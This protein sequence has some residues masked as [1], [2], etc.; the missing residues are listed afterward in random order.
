MPGSVFHALTATTPDNTS[1]EIR[2]Q[3]HWN[4][5][6]L[7]TFAL[8]GSEVIGA[9]TNANGVSFGLSNSSI[10]ASVSAPINVSA[11]N[12]SGNVSALT[13][14][15]SNGLAFGFNN[16]VV[17]G[18]YTVPSTA[19][20]LTGINVSAPGSSAN[21]SAVVF[22]NANGL[23]FGLNGSTLTGAYSQAAQTSLSFANSNGLGF[24]IVGSTL[25]GSYTQAAQTSLS[26]ASGNGIS[27]GINGATLNATISQTNL[28][29]AVSLL[30]N[31]TSGALALVSSGTLFLAG[32]NNITL[33]Q[34]GNS[35][36]VIGPTVQGAQTGISG[37]IAAGSTL[38]SGT[39][40]FSNAVGGVAFGLNGATLTASVAPQTGISSIAVAGSTISNGVVM[41]SNANG[42]SFGLNGS[43]ITASYT[44][45]TFNQTV[46]S[47]SLYASSNTYGQASSTVVDAR[48]ITIIGSG[49]LYAGMSAGA[50]VLS[51]PIGNFQSVGVS[52]GGNTLGNTGLVNQQIVFVGSNNVQLSQSTAA[53][54]SATVSIIASAVAL[55]V[56]AASFSSG[57]VLLSNANGM[58]FGTS[59]GGQIVTASYT[60]PST[61]GLISAVNVSAG[62]ASSN[63]SALSLANM[64]GVS[65]G[66]T[67]G[68]LSASIPSIGGA[69]TGIS[70]IAF[71]NTTF[72]SGGFSFLNANA[73]SFGS[74]G[75]NGITAS[76]STSQSVQQLT[77][78]ATSNTIA[79]EAITGTMDARSISIAGSGN[80]S[81]GYSNGS[82]VIDSP[83][84]NFQSVGVSTGGNTLGNTGLVNQQI[85]FV[86]SNNISLSQSTVAGGS[87]TISIIGNTGVLGGV[88]A[89]FTNGASTFTSGTVS[90]SN[91]NGI[92]F[93]PNGANVVTASYSVPNVAGLISNITVSAAGAAAGAGSS[94]LT[95]ISFANMNG[96]SFG[97]TN[98]SLSAS[99][100][101]IG[102]AQTGISTIAFANTTFTS[103]GFSFL[104]ANSISFGSS[105]ANGITASYAQSVQ[106]L[107]MYA[108]SN[109]IAGQSTLGTFD[110]RSIS[111]AGSGEVSIGYS[112]GSL[113]IGAPIGSFNSIGVSN[114][115]STA[116]S[117]GL[118][119]NQVVLAASGNMLLS[120]STAAGGSATIS[121]IAQAVG[122]QVTN[123]TFT[124]GNVIFSNV[125][126]GVQF[127]TSAGGQIVTASYTVPSTAGLISA[128]NVSAGAASSNLSALS[129]GNANNMSFGYS[130][131]SI[132]GSFSSV[133]PAAQTGISTVAFANTT[134]TSGGFS[135]L[136]ANSISFGSSGANGITASYAQSAQSLGFFVS[137]NTIAGNSTSATMDART[138]IVIGAGNVSLGFSQTLGSN[139]LAISDSYTQSNQSISVYAG[140][141]GNQT[142]NTSAA[143]D[144]RSLSFVG[145]GNISVGN[146]AGAV[147]IYGTQT[148]TA[149]GLSTQGNTGGT[150]GIA[151]N[152]IVFVG[153]NNITLSQS[154]TNGSATISIFGPGGIAAAVSGGG[155][156]LTSGTLMFSNANN[157]TFGY[158]GAAS[159][160][161]ASASYPVQSTQP[162]AA[163]GSNGSIGFSTLTFGS[164]NNFAF[165]ITNGSLVGSLASTAG[166]ALQA[167]TQTGNTSGSVVFSSVTGNG[168][169]IVFGMSNS[170]VITASYSQSA[171]TMGV[172]A[173]GNTTAQSTFSTYDARSLYVSGAGAISAGFSAGTLVISNSGALVVSAGTQAVGV[174]SVVFSS[175]TG[176]GGNIA[177][178]MSNSSVVTASYS[179]SN[180]TMSVQLYGSTTNTTATTVDARSLN[181]S[182]AGNLTVGYSASTLQFS[183]PLVGTNSFLDPT[184]PGCLIGTGQC[185]AG[186]VMVFP[187][188]LGG[189][190][191]LS[192]GVH[193]AYLSLST[194]SNS[195]C[196]ASISMYMGIYS[197]NGSTLN[198]YVT[199]SQSYAFSNTSNNSAAS[200]SGLRAFTVPLTGASLTPGDY[201]VVFMSN[202]TYGGNNWV[203]GSNLVA[204]NFSLPLQGSIGQVGVAS[205]QM[206]MG[207]GVYSAT[208]NALPAGMAFTN[209]VGV[210]TANP[211][212]APYVNFN[213]FSV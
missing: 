9:F 74:S 76:F 16:G 186:S 130:N 11:G 58:S 132:T 65:F 153:T 120:Q 87:A 125:A 4:A 102:G 27:F 149:G 172:Y 107:S 124:S 161:T 23:S 141:A 138:F 53:G 78:Y 6:H 93:G 33:S 137:G 95:A 162:V 152:Q 71:A 57:N 109:T 84:G 117:T 209:I 24:G 39:L 134:F 73:I 7:L 155:S 112:N 83:I 48:S 123:A 37:I 212:Y 213:N 94:T 41:F 104:N 143:Y 169:N 205:K 63:L 81:V 51:A 36:T 38:S 68:S 202:T 77:L 2:P 144:A 150:T 200:I 91:A 10:T 85:V 21:L 115:G 142:Y 174:G 114:L 99:I 188:L 101:S 13:L 180:Q 97:Y 182:A 5:A 154:L 72:T 178:G 111:I 108:T 158:N 193:F 204:S 135:F 96:V 163:S 116:G 42:L 80:V 31:N 170:S 50:L 92:S 139:F 146:S 195:S 199:G 47:L 197:R 17:T 106:A 175:V 183:G 131:G 133:A 18:S 189:N 34:A 164:S 75:A 14:S 32:S 173:L 191:N 35:I 207:Y 167:G 45:P 171:D 211:P 28:Q 64:N 20:L 136:N 90:L 59:A 19:G 40:S 165:Y 62:T 103:G 15:N 100:P 52:T 190:A 12:A 122:L 70:T 29:Q 185:G 156:T 26:F 98:G 166:I 46:Q 60:V 147:V 69:Q 25:T 66:F 176:N 203:T 198:S 43:T 8:V 127:G 192:Q 201:W 129:F 208:S 30:G 61:A 56:G 88:Y 140:T 3:A 49:Q 67:N 151:T 194:S 22:S 89:S 119:G 86:G 148:P 196:A 118:V 128:V 184:P 113:V 55:Q 177:F 168:G 187:L 160:I 82:L 159:I 105:G 206:Q 157:V 44:V 121:M 210:S 110:A 145:S 54:G 181:I 79:G 179:Q 1:Y 126:N